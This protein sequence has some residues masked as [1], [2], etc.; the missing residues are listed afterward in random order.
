[1]QLKEY[2]EKT[3][4]KLRDFLKKA[5]SIGA[6]K[7]FTEAAYLRLMGLFHLTTSY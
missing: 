3:L 5:E 1:M 2:Q 4:N 7:A 6:K